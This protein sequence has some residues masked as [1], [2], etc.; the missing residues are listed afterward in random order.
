MLP[1]LWSLVRTTEDVQALISEIDALEVS[2]YKV[3]VGN[4]DETLMNKVRF[5]VAEIVKNELPHDLDS[6]K[7]YLRELKKKLLELPIL[8]LT[9]PVDVTDKILEEIS[10]NLRRDLNA[11]I[12]IELEKERSILGGAIVSYSGKYI[13]LSLTTKMEKV[14]SEYAG[15]YAEIVY[16]NN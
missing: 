16:G 12:I 8:K 4:W 15:K 13:D 11:E 1:E 3:G 9:I 2:L 7:D 6:R 5:S 10:D 14:W